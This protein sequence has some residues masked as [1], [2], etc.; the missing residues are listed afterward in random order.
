MIIENHNNKPQTY[1]RT[2][3]DSRDI[4]WTMIKKREKRY[5]SGRSFR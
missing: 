5:K 3:I 4:Y 2:H 1:A